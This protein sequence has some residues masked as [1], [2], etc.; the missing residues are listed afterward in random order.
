MRFLDPEVIVD[1]VARDLIN[2]IKNTVKGNYLPTDS[3]HRL[4]RCILQLGNKNNKNSLQKNKN[5]NNQK[6]NDII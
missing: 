4:N 6:C 1:R 3:R 5:V 2:E